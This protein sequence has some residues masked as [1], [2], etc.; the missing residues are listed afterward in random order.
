MITPPTMVSD[1]SVSRTVFKSIVRDALINKGQKN[2]RRLLFPAGGMSQCETNGHCPASAGIGKLADVAA[3][4]IRD[5]SKLK[6]Y[7]NRAAEGNEPAAD[8][9]CR[10]RNAF[11]Y[12]W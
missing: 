12:G 3:D 6:L 2:R 8:E 11:L 7:L 1:Q 5:D 10:L 9:F 4:L